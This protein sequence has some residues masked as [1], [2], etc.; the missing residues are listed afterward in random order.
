MRAK[1]W[2]GGSVGQRKERGGS[3]EFTIPTCCPTDR[4]SS[5]D[6][7]SS[8]SRDLA[9]WFYEDGKGG[10]MQCGNFITCKFAGGLALHFY[11]H[12]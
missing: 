8:E 4:L 2:S 12:D 10:R 11:P 6:D 7:L 9:N 3:E 5:F 1:I